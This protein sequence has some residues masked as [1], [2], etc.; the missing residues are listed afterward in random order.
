MTPDRT[1]FIEYSIVSGRSVETANGSVMQCIGQGKVRIPVRVEGHT[2]SVVL[3][4]VLHVPQIRGNL[5][6]VTKIQD[7]GLVV[8][9]TA[10]PK[11]KTMVIKN[12]GRTVGVASRIGNAFLLDM[13]PEDRAFPATEVAGPDRTRYRTE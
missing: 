8:E 5:I 2:S 11:K 6:S 4:D 3:S 13:Q 9:T 12:Q 10:P 1:T 7:K